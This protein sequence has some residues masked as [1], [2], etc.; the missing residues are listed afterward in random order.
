MKVKEIINKSPKKFKPFSIEIKFESE[1][2][3]RDMWAIFNMSESTLNQVIKAER[4]SWKGESTLTLNTSVI[5]K[6][7][8]TKLEEINNI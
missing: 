8:N 5:W 4:A 3:L 7:L 6:V 2:E 1:K